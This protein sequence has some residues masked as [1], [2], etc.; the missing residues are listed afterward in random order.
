MFLSEIYWG[1][2]I[3]FFSKERLIERIL[4]PLANTKS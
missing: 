1:R 2:L 4:G 3:E